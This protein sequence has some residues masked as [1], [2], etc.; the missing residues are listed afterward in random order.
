ML[1]YFYTAV[2]CKKSCK[3]VYVKTILCINIFKPELKIQR[4]M[5]VY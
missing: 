3:H 1:R 2:T 5:F 4:N